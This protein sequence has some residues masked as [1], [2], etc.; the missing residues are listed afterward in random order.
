MILNSD[1]KG[2]I[3]APLPLSLLSIHLAF[4]S[5]VFETAWKSKKIK[6]KNWIC[7]DLVDKKQHYGILVITA[8]KEEVSLIG[9]YREFFL[10]FLGNPEATNFGQSFL[11]FFTLL[12]HTEDF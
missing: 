4:S 3:K 5:T 12:L 7:M 1:Q 10:G 6:L 2:T 9:D 8:M 11:H